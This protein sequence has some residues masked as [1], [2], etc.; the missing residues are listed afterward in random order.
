MY[1][2]NGYV[3]VF[4]RLFSMAGNNNSIGPQ[5]FGELLHDGYF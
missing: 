3:N 1:K 4:D 2:K 5:A